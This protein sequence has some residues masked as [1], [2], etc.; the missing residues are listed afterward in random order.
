MTCGRYLK[1]VVPITSTSCFFRFQMIHIFLLPPPQS[2][3][4]EC[5]QLIFIVYHEYVTPRI[6]SLERDIK[7]MKA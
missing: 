5:V 2:Y 7:Q 3:Q 4:T 1:T 6:F